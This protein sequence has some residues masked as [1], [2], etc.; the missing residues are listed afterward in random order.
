MILLQAVEEDLEMRHAAL[1]S[2][3][4]TAEELLRQAG[5][6][7]D[8]AVRGQYTLIE[9]IGFFCFVLS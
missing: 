5:N 7:Q 2:V 8:E 1:E 9:N 4:N 6:E 3:K